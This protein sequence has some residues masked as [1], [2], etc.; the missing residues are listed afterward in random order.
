MKKLIGVKGG[1]KDDHLSNSI[2]SGRFYLCAGA[3]RLANITGTCTNGLTLANIAGVKLS[4]IEVSGYQ[5]ALLT[6]T[7]VRGSGLGDFK[8]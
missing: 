1:W 8:K 4:N 7:K 2:S 3:V 5:G 6:T